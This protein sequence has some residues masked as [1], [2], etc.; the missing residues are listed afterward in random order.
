MDPKKFFILSGLLIILLTCSLS[1]KEAKER[2]DR[3]DIEFSEENL[4]YYVEQG[5]VDV[6]K[7]F[8]LAGMAPDVKRGDK[9][10][11]LEAARRAHS[12][13]ALILI[14][15]GSD[16][17]AKDRFGVTS[18]MF[19]AITGSDE[20]MKK[21]IER[22]ADVNAKDNYGRTALVEMLTT[23]NDCPPEIIQTLID[24]GADVNVKIER[25]LTPLMLAADGD[26]KILRILIDAGADLDAKDDF[27]TTAIIRAK[28]NPENFKI[29]K[30]AGA[31]DS[32]SRRNNT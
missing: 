17:N 14:D 20:I 8:L 23:E 18:L 13:V 28:D 24:A 3:L 26:P 10:A 1:E 25:G 4:Y 22:G 6:V 11:L 12:E 16:I 2:L 5:D 29:L 19:A 21:L 32:S 31:I 15:A 9:T 30:N 27:G 7:L